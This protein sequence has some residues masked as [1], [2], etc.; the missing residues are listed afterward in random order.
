M[1]KLIANIEANKEI[2]KNLKKLNHYSADM[3]L[4]DMKAYVKAIKERRML[5]IIESVSASG[6]SRVLKFNA[7][8][9]KKGQF[10]YRQFRCLFIA[11]GYSEAKNS[12]GFRVNGCGMDMV[13]HTNYSIIHDIKRV[14]LIDQEECAHLAQQTPVVL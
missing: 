8:E 14:G 2:M 6:M 5:C 4:N 11:L 10:N 12:Y 1:K 7:C 9:G 13:F 3:L